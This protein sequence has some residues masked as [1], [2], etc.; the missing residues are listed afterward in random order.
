MYNLAVFIHVLAAFMIAYSVIYGSLNKVTSSSSKIFRINLL[1]LSSMSIISLLSATWIIS[2]ANYSH[3]ALWIMSSYVLWIVLILI[4]EGLIRRKYV[5]A[6]R[7]QTVD[8]NVFTE[9]R[10]MVL[11][12]LVLTFLMIF[13][14]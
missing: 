12:V 10:I 4:N 1:I 5:K 2:I 7:S 9:Y 3:S 8:V 14:P 13:K 11:I 6:N